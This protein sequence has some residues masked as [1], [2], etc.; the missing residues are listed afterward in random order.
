MPDMPTPV[1]PLVDAPDIRR[2]PE[3]SPRKTEAMPLEG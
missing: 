3:Q 1:R 2:A